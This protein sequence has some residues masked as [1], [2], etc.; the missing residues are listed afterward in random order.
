MAAKTQR[1]KENH[2]EFS[3]FSPLSTDELLSLF[4]RG[5]IPG[6]S[7]TEAEFLARASSKSPLP[8]W[9][10]IPPLPP[11]WGFSVDWVPLIYSKKN[12]LPW[13]GALCR[14]THIQLHPRLQT[15]S[16]FGNT[17]TQ[18]L[19]HESVHAVREAFDE[20]QFE[21]LIAYRTAPTAWKR[22]IGPLF[23]RVWEFPLFTA[24]LFFLPLACPIPLFF[25]LRLLYKQFLFHRN[26]LPLPILLCLTDQEIRSNKIFITHLPRSRLIAALLNSVFTS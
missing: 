10:S 1:R 17:L 21:E 20:P 16:L 12:L 8:E 11:Q 7:E 9:S 5:L 14:D 2:T 19:H 6:P 13:E 3:A 4:R 23:S 15:K 24:S 18:I 26:K 25:C 22:F